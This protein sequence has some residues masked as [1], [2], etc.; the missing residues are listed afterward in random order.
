M[1]TA[2]IYVFSGTYHTLKAAAMICDALERSCFKTRVCE[3]RMPFNTIPSPDGYDIV[4]FGYPVHAF[5]APEV[6]IR[7][8]RNLP[9]GS[10]R[11][12]IFKTSGEPFC[13]TRTSS[14]QLYRILRRKG[15]DVG[16]ETHMLM[17]YNIMFLIRR[18]WS[19]QMYLYT[20]AQ[21]RLTALRIL[22]VNAIRYVSAFSPSPLHSFFVSNG[23]LPVNSP[24][25]L[26][27]E[28]QV[29]EM[30][31]LRAQVP[32]AEYPFRQQR[33]S[34]FRRSLRALYALRHVLPP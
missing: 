27:K 4:G 28:K 13:L 34:A 20:E 29:Y 33:G 10:S 2:I 14:N 12:F 17:P 9:S 18:R 31:P 25:L 3:I 24:F 32:Y 15:Y 23:S 5:N 30:R 19:S 26:R 22:R 21:S 7:F 8:V 6:F 11:C 1:K 16:F